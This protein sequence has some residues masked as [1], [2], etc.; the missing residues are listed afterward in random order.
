[1][2]ADLRLLRQL[3]EENAWHKAND[4]WLTSL[5]PVGGLIRVKSSNTHLWV[6]K[7]NDCA[8]LCWPAEETEPNLWRKAKAVKELI[9]YT[10][11]DLNDVE[12]L[13][14]QVESPKSLFLQER[15]PTSLLLGI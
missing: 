8:S 6:L 10:C 7:T 4:A 11:F 13:S 2:V 15:L 12:V 9:W 1:M 14:L 5:L 3:H